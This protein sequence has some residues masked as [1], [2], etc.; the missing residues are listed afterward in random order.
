MPHNNHK[1]SLQL[2]HNSS[3]NKIFSNSSGNSNKWPTWQTIPFIYIYI[4]IFIYLFVY[5]FNSIL[6]MFQGTLCSSSGESIVPIQHLVY[7]TLCR[8]LSSMQVRK[9]RGSFLTCILD[10]HLH[11]VTYTRCCIG[12][13]DS[14]D[15]EHK[16]AQ[17]M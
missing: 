14:P 3:R 16:V 13:I 11:R 6:Y 7:V 9:E 2:Y 5:I 4:Y 10:G 8:W 12:T 15:D 17:N 1:N